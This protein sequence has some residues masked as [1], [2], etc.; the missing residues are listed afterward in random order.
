MLIMGKGPINS[1]SWKSKDTPLQCH[2]YPPEIAGRKKWD[3]DAFSSQKKRPAFQTLEGVGP[4]DFHENM[5]ILGGLVGNLYN[6]A[7]L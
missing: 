3:Y 2:V 4:L 1:K 6:M 5:R 7:Y